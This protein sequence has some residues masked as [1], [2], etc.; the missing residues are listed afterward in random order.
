MIALVTLRALRGKIASLIPNINTFAVRGHK[1]TR[2]ILRKSGRK[3]GSALEV[4]LCNAGLLHLLLF[5]LTVSSYRWLSAIWMRI[6][7]NYAGLN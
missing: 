1:L 7:G 6:F 3:F 5:S 2:N 4:T